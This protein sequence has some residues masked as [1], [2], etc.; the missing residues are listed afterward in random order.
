MSKGCCVCDPPIAAL[1]ASKGRPPH[2]GGQQP[3]PAVVCI[4]LLSIVGNNAISGNA[5]LADLVEALEK[6]LPAS[7]AMTLPDRRARDTGLDVVLK[8]RR[9]GAQGASVRV[10]LKNRVEP[11]DVDYLAA[12]LQPTSDRPVLI[13][14]PFLSPRTQQRLKESGFAYADLAGNVRLSLSEPGLFI[15]T[16]GAAENP[17]PSLRE[18]KS[19]KG[20]KAGRLVRA[21]CDFRP[22]TGLRELA[23]RAGVDAGYAS[24]LIEL[25]NRE[26]LVTR[27]TRGPI[28]SVDWEALLK[29]WSQEYSPFRRGGSKMYLAPRGLSAVLDKLKSTRTRYAVTGS[30]AASQVA[31]IAPPRLLMLYVE[32]P[33][34]IDRDLDLRPA[35]AG[36]NVA[37]LTPFDDVVFDR[38]SKK[39]DITIAALSQVAAD[40]L[41]SPGRGPNEGEALMEWMRDN[42]GAWRA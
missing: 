23:K 41:T 2:S 12:T 13:A 17:Q 19:I 28:T 40:L 42:E 10:Q 39:Q 35:E 15:E 3:D 5:S 26:A 18:R 1:S 22:P 31:P 21:L 8:V 14:A 6:R 24:R 29:R 27:A 33:A 32:R 30:W 38:T 11:R 4:I 16:T 25:L 34:T 20:G 7:W 36:T 9:R 37:L